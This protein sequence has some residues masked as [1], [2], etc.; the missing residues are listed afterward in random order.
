MIRI[1]KEEWNDKLVGLTIE[2]DIIT[3]S[4]QLLLN[5]GT[6]LQSQHLEL[7][8]NHYI[9]YICIRKHHHQ[10]NDSFYKKYDSNISELKNV[11]K[12]VI[13]REAPAL[14]E[15]MIPFM[16]IIKNVLEK[17][18]LFLELH[19][20]RGHDEYTYRHSLN[21]GLF[22][23]TIGRILKVSDEEVL[24]LAKCGLM[25]DIGKLHIDSTILTKDSGLT[26]AEF[27]EIKKHPL[28]GKAILEKMNGVTQEHMDATLYHHERLD[29]SGYPYQL[30]GDDIPLS[31]QIIAIADM[32]DA[33]S[34]D[35]AY[36]G[37]FSPFDTLQILKD[38]TFNGKLQASISLPFINHILNGYRGNS[39]LLNNG[40]TGTVIRFDL[41]HI[42]S[43][44]V[45]IDQKVVDLRK[46]SDLSVVQIYHAN[47]VQLI[48]E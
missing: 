46:H 10:E 21:V 25:H 13:N 27:A 41:D 12:A 7:L 1:G 37:K 42:D 26:D 20:I 29:G 30:V 38:D 23:A 32:Y 34:S 8:K 15:F 43:P 28:Y 9:D 44:L 17:P 36:R 39:V 33:I 16:P 18:Y 5:K 40:K 24:E 6:I 3:A 45:K 47:D 19:N 11:F 35:R 4:G 2:E 48:L 14:R 31:A 22:A